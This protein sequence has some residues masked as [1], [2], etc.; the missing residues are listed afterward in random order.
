VALDLMCNYFILPEPV[1]HNLLQE[2]KLT[3]KTKTD[4]TLL[5]GILVTSIKYKLWP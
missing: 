3:L 2:Q 4:I 1:N 5:F